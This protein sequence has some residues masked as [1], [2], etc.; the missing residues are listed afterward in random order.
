[1][2]VSTDEVSGEVNAP[3][4]SLYEAM[5]APRQ[6]T[7]LDNVRPG[8]HSADDGQT[9]ADDLTSGDGIPSW[10]GEACW[11]WAD[12]D[13]EI[14]A[15]I[16]ITEADQADGASYLD[17]V[18]NA[19]AACDNASWCSDGSYWRHD[20]ETF[21]QCLGCRTAIANHL[22]GCSQRPKTLFSLDFA[23]SGD[24]T[25]SYELEEAWITALPQ[26]ANA[27]DGV[28]LKV[29]SMYERPD[30]PEHPHV[31][32]VRDICS[33]LNLEFYWCRRLWVTWPTQSSRQ[34]EYDDYL[35]SAYYA[36]CLANL[37]AEAEALA[38]TG[39][40]IET[41]PYG[42]CI[43]KKGDWRHS[44]DA[45]RRHKVLAIIDEGVAGIGRAT[46]ACPAGASS[47]EGYGYTMRTLGDSYKHHKTYRLRGIDSVD[48]IPAT[49]PEGCPLSLHWWGTWLHSG[50]S[51]GSG[52]LSL[53]EWQA[54][55][56]P[57]IRSLAPELQG[58][59][60]YAPRNDCEAVLLMLGGLEPPV[61]GE[62]VA[63]ERE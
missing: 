49:P 42:Q 40:C 10:V 11:K 21:A 53:T 56:W 58:N 59:W 5:D 3:A 33:H 63:A 52:P 38:A 12:S 62:P 46:I 26:A 57:R 16:G 25:E 18:S 28:V 37:K 61:P 41:E 50:E 23:L 6:A 13:A 48:D 29:W 1:M 4:L 20:P 39:T 51:T 24:G 8:R 35:D 14:G 36:E 55:Q 19:R 31:Q 15:L 44:F 60:L 45:E 47:P 22:Y 2:R 54:I 32:Q 17:V 7:Y 43:Y 30:A 9:I 34:Q 27:I